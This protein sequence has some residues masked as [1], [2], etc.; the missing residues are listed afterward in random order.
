VIPYGKCHSVAVRYYG[1]PLAATCTFFKFSMFYVLSTR[2]IPTFIGAK[3]DDESVV[4]VTPVNV[5][6]SRSAVEREIVSQTVY[7][8]G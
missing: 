3:D 7:V 1:V 8:F 5:I 6:S 4:P 2:D